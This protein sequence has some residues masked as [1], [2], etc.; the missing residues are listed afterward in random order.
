MARAT[1]Y[2]LE[3]AEKLE[4]LFAG[5]PKKLRGQILRPILREA[6]KTVQAEA[7]QRAPSAT[8]A[9]RDAIKVRASKKLKKGQ[10][11]VD[12][13][14]GEGNYRGKT[15]YGAFLEFGAPKHEL[16]GK[17]LSPLPPQPFMRPAFD[18]VKDAVARTAMDAIAQAIVD[19]AK[20]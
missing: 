10:V 19:A 2:K 9:V 7:K 12:V 14:I 5:L 17:K 11:G 6:A 15:F 16:F 3:G 4:K 18:A 8:G 13:S 20:G 1:R